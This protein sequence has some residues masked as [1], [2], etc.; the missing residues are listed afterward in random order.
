MTSAAFSFTLTSVEVNTSAAEFHFYPNPTAGM[1]NITSATGGK[2]KVTNVQGV[3][4]SEYELKQGQ[5]IV[6]FPE[7]TAAGVYILSFTSP[8]IMRK[9]RVSKVSYCP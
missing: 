4:V 1:I 7:N 3:I 5:T 8:G 6:Q 9:A 2:L